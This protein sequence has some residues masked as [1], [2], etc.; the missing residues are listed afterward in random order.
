MDLLHVPRR[1]MISA[2]RLTARFLHYSEPGG[3]EAEGMSHDDP[4]DVRA[5]A[6]AAGEDADGTVTG[7]ILL[8]GGSHTDF[9]PVRDRSLAPITRVSYP[10]AVRSRHRKPGLSSSS[11]D[12][13]FTGFLGNKVLKYWSR[14]LSTTS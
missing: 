12:T 1:E 4:D 3:D 13:F 2:L 6:E 11:S 8:G 10:V 9:W 5:V 14:H 7:F